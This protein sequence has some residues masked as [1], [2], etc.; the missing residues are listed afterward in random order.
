MAEAGMAD[1]PLLINEGSQTTW[2]DDVSGAL[3]GSPSKV[4]YPLYDDPHVMRQSQS[5]AYVIRG[6]LVSMASGAAQK[7]TYGID[8]GIR[9]DRFLTDLNNPHTLTD[10]ALAWKFGSELFAGGQRQIGTRRVGSKLRKFHFAASDGR[11]GR[12]YWC[13]DQATEYVDLTAFDS[14]VNALGAAITLTASYVVTNSP[15]L[16]FGASGL[17]D[18][19]GGSPIPNGAI[20]LGGEPFTLGGN[21][22]T[23]GT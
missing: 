15:I 7:V 22:I 12:A 13:D 16:V 19:L 6:I 17:P 5:V 21:F 23:L 9:G 14:G 20:T 11:P 4:S 18:V 1:K 8:S 10:A 3:F 2:R